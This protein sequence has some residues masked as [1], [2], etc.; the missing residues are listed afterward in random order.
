MSGSGVEVWIHWGVGVAVSGDDN[1][2][3][4]LVARLEEMTELDAWDK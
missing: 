4:E 2:I 1:I 3:G